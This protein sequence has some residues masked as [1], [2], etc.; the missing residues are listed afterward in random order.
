MSNRDDA[1]S[2]QQAFSLH[3]SGKFAEAAKLYRKV[4]KKNPREAN[5][6]HSLVLIEAAAGSRA[7]AAQLM[8]RPLAVQP[9]NIQFI[10]NY[11]TVLCQIGKF[12]TAST[13]CSR[14]LEL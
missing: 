9:K 2:L 4:I 5:A 13:E 3:R 10:R 14:G 8:A 1:Q 11:V 12:K 7:E 6:L